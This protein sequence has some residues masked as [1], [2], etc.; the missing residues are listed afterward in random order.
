MSAVR[1]N[2]GDFFLGHPDDPLAVDEAFVE[3]RRA[4]PELHALMERTLATAADP[5]TTLVTPG[6]EREV[7]NLASLDY[8]GICRHPEVVEAQREA[9]LTWGSGAC[10]VPLLS[11]MTVEH[12]ALEAAMCELTQTS[13]TILFTSGFSGALGVCSALLRRGDIAILDRYAHMSWVDG[14]QMANARMATFE[15][16]D[17][18]ELDALLT[19]HRGRRRVVIVDGLYSMD[20]DL[21]DLPALLDVC[22]HHGVGMIVDEAHSIFAMGERGG[23][24]TEHFGVQDRVRLLF[25]TFSKAL[26]VVGAF[27]SG[28]SDL[29]DYIRYYAHPYVFSAALPPATVAGIRRGV[30]IVRSKPGFRRRL[31]ENAKWFRE[32][33]QSRGFD[34]GASTTHVVPVILG[35][36]RELLY[37]GTHAL[38]EAGVF[39]APVDFPAVAEDQLRIRCAVSAGH[40]REDLTLA[41]DRITEVFATARRP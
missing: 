37:R 22:D 41:V 23:G 40:S 11:G 35:A 16:N 9:L 4:E 15:H 21:A 3:W 28:D 13:G 12:R 17:P 19:E 5:H 20:G 7:V 26:S 6:G 1:Q 32:T 38:M 31:E 36:D 18:E 2:L 27:V 29:I 8:L 34:T 10:G 25:G 24:A 39:V 33:L 30:E 14:V